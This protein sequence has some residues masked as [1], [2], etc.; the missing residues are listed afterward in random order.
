[1]LKHYLLISWRNIVR[2][3][4]YS[5]ILITGLAVGIASSLMLGMYAYDELTYDNFHEKKDRIFLVGVDSKEGNEE[6]RSGWTTPPTGPALKEFFPEVE[7]VSRLCF[8]FDDVV[9]TRG[10]QKHAED[11]IVGADSTVFDVFTI[12]FLQGNPKTALRE[13]NTVVITEKTA[14]KYFGTENPVGQTILFDQFFHECKVTGVVKDYPANSHFTFDFLLSLSSFKNI[15]FDFTDSWT[16]HTFSTYVVLNGNTNRQRVES[17]MP[18]FLKAYYEPYFVKRFGKTLSEIYKGNDHYT[19]F[20]MP[21]KDVHL[22]TM[23]FENQEGKEM[24]TYALVIIALIILVLVS[25]NYTNLATALSLQRSKEVGIR[26][27]TG[28]RSG[29]LFI[30]FLL[31]SVLVAFIGLLLGIAMLEVTLPFFN[32]LSGKNL[33]V[34]YADPFMLLALVGFA[35]MLGVL[36]GFYPALSFA[37]FNP[38]RALKGR[39]MIKG[40]REWLRSGLVISQFTIC[41]VMIVCTLVAYKQL[42]YMTTRNLGFAKDHLVVLKRPGGLGDN[43]SAFKNELLK[44]PGV[45]QVS[46]VNTTPGRHFDGHG[47][48]FAGTPKDEDPTVFPLVADADI[49]ETLS[50]KMVQGKTF[51]AGE[52]PQAILNEAAV[53]ALGMKDPLQETIDRGT[54]GDMDVNIVGV[55]KDFHFQSFHHAIEPMVIY[56]RNGDL[57]KTENDANYILVKV[58]G[59]DMTATLKGIEKTWKQLSNGYLFE[60]SFLDED[61]NKLFAR[62][63]TT[64]H[65]YT[66]FSVIAIVIASIGLL[67]LASF[68]TARRTKEIGV[69]KVVGAS[70]LNIA[71]LLSRDFIRWLIVATLLGSAVSFYLIQQWL[72]NFAYH[73]PLPWWVFVLAGVLALFVMVLA[74]G[75]H[76]FQ[77]ARRN[78]TEALRTE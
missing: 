17:R 65:I 67:G 3:R 59:A 49:L 44:Q 66:A 6:G 47:Q 20:L 14:K 43:R 46:Y 78:P 11:H 18:Q 48:H 41:I 35:V 29:A 60:Y 56:F 32:A 53:K 75:W 36:S 54:L 21:L 15:G 70:I 4:F 19:L 33:H 8:W 63:Q 71:A 52:K 74:L 68:F 64:A 10:D 5:V 72:S 12:P 25:I 9:V 34:N 57:R 55:V 24:L 28:S 30:Q 23:I 2:N 42:Q 16:N 31:E 73:T 39:A 13:P 1:M 77:A 38:V 27:V 37:S 50:L 45:L 62:E 7:K 58:K 69:R 22:S 51:A 26:K 61:F 40:N 76:I